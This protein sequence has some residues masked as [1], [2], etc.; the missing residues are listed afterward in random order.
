MSRKARKNLISKF[1]H[2]MVQGINKEYI[3]KES[4]YKKKYLYLLFSNLKKFNIEIISFCPMDNHAHLLFYYE[5]YE[6]VINL[7]HIMNTTYA[8][9]Y[10]DINNRVGY[11]F[12]D[13][14]RVEE[15]KDLHHLYACI[16]YIHNN[17]IKAKI[18]EK[19]EDYAFS[20]YKEY[21]NNC[22][23]CN[24]KMMSIL[25]LTRND[26]EKLFLNPNSFNQGIYNLNEPQKVIEEFLKNKNFKS[27][28]EVKEINDKKELIEFLKQEC[29]ISYNEIAGNLG[30]SRSSVYRILKKEAN[31]F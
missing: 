22:G 24:Q 25:Q 6:E 15:I 29:K 16:N 9:W 10:N 30:K 12:R 21:L 28:D 8:R 20:S 4:K 11:V 14:Y 2:I 31:K 27:I 3:F 5:K 18:V 7:M 23:I 13:R 19:P 17:P 1:V 26:I